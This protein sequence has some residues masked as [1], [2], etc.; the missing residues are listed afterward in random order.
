MASWAALSS[1]IVEYFQGEDFYRCGYCKNE[2]GSRSNGE[3]AGGPPG[4]G[5]AVLGAPRLAGVLGGRGCPTRAGRLE[6]P[7]ALE[8]PPGPCLLEEVRNA[9]APEG[10]QLL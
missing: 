7:A 2:S 6:R 3:L 5:V 9:A 4:E 1:S 8:S 10:P